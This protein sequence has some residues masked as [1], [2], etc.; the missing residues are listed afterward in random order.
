MT[1]QSRTAIV[2]GAA[3]GIGVAIAKRLSDDGLLVA[4]L[5]LDEAA[6]KTVVDEIEA[7]RGQA[8]AVGADVSDEQGVGR[9]RTSRPPLP[10]RSRWA[11]WGSRRTSPRWCRSLPART[12]PSC[13]VRSSTSPVALATELR[14]VQKKWS[15]EEIVDILLD[16]TQGRGRTL[17][18]S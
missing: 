4:V 6:C 12:R 14:P 7:S 15:M 1:A 16:V 10:R 3:R 8:L 2:T 11:A 18:G 9:P 5:D 13:R 17:P